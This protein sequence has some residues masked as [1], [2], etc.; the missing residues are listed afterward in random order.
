MSDKVFIILYITMFIAWVGIFPGFIINFSS[1]T[2]GPDDIDC[3]SK[4]LGP[5]DEDVSERKLNGCQKHCEIH[6]IWY[7]WGKDADCYW[8][9]E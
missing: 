9:D 8:D 4:S 5:H 6:P 7:N 3:N 1:G 2:V